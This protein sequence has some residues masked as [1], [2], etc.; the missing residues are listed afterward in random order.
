[1]VATRAM[2]VIFKSHERRTTDSS[3][4]RGKLLLCLPSGYYFKKNEK[5]NGLTP[6]SSEQS[7]V[8]R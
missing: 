3:T 5:E 4:L 6:L 2:T 1:M 7:E 8:E